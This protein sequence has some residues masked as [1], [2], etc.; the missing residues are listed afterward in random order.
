MWGFPFY[1]CK[2]SFAM[3]HVCVLS[4]QRQP[5]VPALSLILFPFFLYLCICLKF[6]ALCLSCAENLALEVLPDTDPFSCFLPS[7]PTTDGQSGQLGRQDPAW[8]LSE[9]SGAL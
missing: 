1:L 6:P 4:I 7:G 2:L 3:G 8:C 5:F 9:L